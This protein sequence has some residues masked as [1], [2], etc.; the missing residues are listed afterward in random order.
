MTEFYAKFY[1]D[2]LRI[3]VREKKTETSVFEGDNVYGP[4]EADSSLEA[5]KKA[6]DFFTE[7]MK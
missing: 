7:K 4:I 3:S 5:A 2:T 1:P 6:K